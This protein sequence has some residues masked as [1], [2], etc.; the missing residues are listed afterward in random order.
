VANNLRELIEALP[1]CGSKAALRGMAAASAALGDARLPPETLSRMTSI[2]RHWR[3]TD[4]LGR[5]EA[6]LDQLSTVDPSR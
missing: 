4:P 1:E 5:L 2:V 3:E 6:E